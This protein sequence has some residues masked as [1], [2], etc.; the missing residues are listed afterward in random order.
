MQNA[1]WLGMAAW[2]VLLA[3]KSLSAPRLGM[4]VWLWMAGCA[5]AGLAAWQGVD[6]GH[7]L[8]TGSKLL[9]A[10]IAVFAGSAAAHARRRDG[11]LR[12]LLFFSAL[13]CLIAGLRALAPLLAALWRGHAWY[14]L[15]EIW[16]NTAG[17]RAHS[18]SGGYMVLASC[19]ML[20][21]CLGL[22]L[23]AKDSPGNGGTGQWRTPGRLAGL[24]CLALGLL[25]T[26]TRGA[27]L[28]AAAGLGL[29]A[30]FWRP[31]A[32]GAGLVLAAL[33]LCF[34]ANRARL[35]N[36]AQGLAHARSASSQERIFLF[37]A[38]AALAAE[39]PWWGVGD[40][41]RAVQ[42]D[43]DT[44]LE[45]YKTQSHRAWE[46]EKGIAKKQQGHLHNNSLQLA[47]MYG[48]P[49]AALL[50]SALL[51]LWA[52]LLRGAA[53]H[54][55]GAGASLGAAAAWLAWMV[56]G[57]FEYTLGSVQSSM[58]FWLI[59]GLGLA[60]LKMGGGHVR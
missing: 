11:I 15:V 30:L 17:L 43:G 10:A 39:N 55:G 46:L 25:M 13:W 21:L 2:L 50:T 24:A 5:W 32:V 1:V 6:R 8:D 42:A 52:G 34:P 7:S 54:G 45:K 12:G 29:V 9:L 27:W 19:S 59:M 48:L 28:G 60:S 40:S 23:A 57:M 38:A 16:M 22:G 36:A 58:L 4:W 49:G 31:R 44:L 56:N 14:Y 33:L 26:A 20:V 18:A 53:S 41:L 37:Q 51:W 35:E 3:R 47:V